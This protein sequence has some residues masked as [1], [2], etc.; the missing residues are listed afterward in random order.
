[1]IRRVVRPSA[2]A[3]PSVVTVKTS[4]YTTRGSL[5]YS[6]LPANYWLHIIRKTNHR[7]TA[8]QMYLTILVEW[9]ANHFF[10]VWRKSIYF[11][12]WSWSYDNDMS[13][14]DFYILVHSD[15]NLWPLMDGVQR[16]S[17]PECYRSCKINSKDCFL[18]ANVVVTLITS[19]K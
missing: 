4:T 9:A 12:W 1:M 14:K 15:I 3:K 11:W 13:K 17:I 6:A 19:R 18:C 10:L 16:R 7:P 5:R 8:D 2:T